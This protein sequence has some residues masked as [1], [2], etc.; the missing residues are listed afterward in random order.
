MAID[1]IKPNP[2]LT[3]ALLRGRRTTPAKIANE[4]E[5]IT[6]KTALKF[7]SWDAKPLKMETFCTFF[8]RLGVDPIKYASSDHSSFSQETL[9]GDIS[10]NFTNEKDPIIRKVFFNEFTPLSTNINNCSL[11]FEID[12]DV[13]NTTDESKKLIKEIGELITNMYGEATDRK[14][15]SFKAA[16]EKFESTTRLTTALIELREEYDT[17]LY[18]GMWLD[19]KVDKKQ[20][21]DDES[22]LNY[23]EN[24][25]TS[26]RNLG[27]LFTS[28]K[29]IR[30]VCA[31]VSSEIEPPLHSEPLQAE[32]F[33]VNY[34]NG[35]RIPHKSE[36]DKLISDIKKEREEEL[37]GEELPWE[38]FD[39]MLA[40]HNEEE[41]AM[42]HDPRDDDW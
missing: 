26:I 25:W 28:E 32:I 42:A 5:G 40:Q 19:W 22:M 41:A 13:K 27:F 36:F 30:N 24:T 38:H 18:S 7:V 31:H 11:Y 23:N 8:N 29:N 37:G 4:G 17:K 21:Y 10:I 12:V 20:K 1:S 35:T 6:E 15:F 33:E 9:G 34:V 14:K 3:R 16:E 39:E 2:L